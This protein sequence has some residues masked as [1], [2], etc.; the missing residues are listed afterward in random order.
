MRRDHAG[1]DL[2][3][4]DLFGQARARHPSRA[5]SPSPLTAADV[6]GAVFLDVDLRA[7]LFLDLADRLAAWADD[8]ADL[9]GVDLDRLDARRERRT[10]RAV[11]RRCVSSIL[12]M[13]NM[14]PSLACARAFLHDLQ[15]DALDLDVHLQRGD[16]IRRARD[17]EVH[18]AQRVFH[19]L[20]VGE[21][22]VVAGGFAV[23][24]DQ[25]HRHARDRGA[26]SARR[27][28][29]APASMPQTE[30]IE[31]EPLEER[32]SETMRMV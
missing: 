18:V 9:F 16:A 7:R 10:G 1:V 27:H 4:L 3:N 23:A 8:R 6:D 30:P 2:A 17:L 11:A 26:E 20:N 31:V 21:D 12:S 15:R 22:G 5:A 19:A 14:R 28:P 29:S 24:G 32:I 25:A 13:M